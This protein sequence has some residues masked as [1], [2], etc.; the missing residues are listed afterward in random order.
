MIDDETRESGG[1]MIDDETGGPLIADSALLALLV[2]DGVLLAVAGLA[3]TPLHIGGVPAPLGALASIL[4]LPWLVSRA[5]E[6]DARPA[7]AGAPLTG[8]GLTVGVLGLAGPGGD[9]LLPATWQ[10]MLL[11][12]GGLGAGL[13]ALRRV[14]D[15]EYEKGRSRG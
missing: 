9:V 11:V 12:I 7:L 1:G 5:A 2:A 10:S 8:W 14:L 13:V 3:Y 4:L 15:R 6:L